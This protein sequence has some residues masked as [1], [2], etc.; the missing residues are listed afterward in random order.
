MAIPV[1][2]ATLGLIVAASAMQRRAPQGAGDALL[3]SFAFPAAAQAAIW[4]GLAPVLVDVDPA[5]WHL[6]P[7][8]L[9]AALHERHGRVGLVVALSSFGKPPP[10]AVRARWEYAC[11]TAGVPLL[12]DSAAGFGAVAEDARPIGTQGDAE[13]VSFHATKPLAAGE[14]GAVFTRDPE[15]AAE[16]ERR[17]NLGF[18][19]ARQVVDADGIN[20]KMRE[21][22]A[23]VTLAALDTFPGALAARRDATRRLLRRLE[24]APVPQKDH[25]LGTHQFVSVAAPDPS[26]RDRV[27][28]AADGRVSL[29]TYY[30]P[31]HRTPAFRGCQVAGRL[32]VT[33][34]L[35]DRMLSLPMAVD[36]TE[37]EAVEIAAVVDEGLRAGERTGR[38]PRGRVAVTG[39]T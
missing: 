20:A 31:L 36:L 25:E 37:G 32:E 11:R 10:A 12:L 5:H 6:S 35:A 14:G 24:S 3:P 30:E 4:N 28:A 19:A 27:L 21:P 9:E 23:A 38:H 26:S 15:I 13:I 2:N 17:I 18:D 39:Q 29:R 22:A 34:D 7:A 16:V 1:A 33:N 8:A